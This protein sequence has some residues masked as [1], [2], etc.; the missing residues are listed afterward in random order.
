MRLPA[1]RASPITIA[2]TAITGLAPMRSSS[3]PAT[4][5]A[6][7]APRDPISNATDSAPRP[8]PMSSAM[9]LRK[10][11]KVLKTMPHSANKTKKQAATM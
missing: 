4:G 5:P 3:V 2:P 8:Q 1:N 6:T 7:A 11:G 10:I 9:G